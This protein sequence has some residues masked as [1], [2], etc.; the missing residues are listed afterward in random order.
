MKT[1]TTFKVTVDVPVNVVTLFVDA[2]NRCHDDEDGYRPLT[3]KQVVKNEKAMRAI[4]KYLKEA[5]IYWAHLDTGTVR[6]HV[7]FERLYNNDEI[8]KVY[9]VIEGVRR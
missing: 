7:W 6:E 2:I 3:A 4:K 1:E 9:D 5:L 8:E